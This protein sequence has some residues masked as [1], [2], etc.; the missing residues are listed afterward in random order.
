MSDKKS[1]FIN[2]SAGKEGH[3]KM[4]HASLKGKL[5]EKFH[6]VRIRVSVKSQV[7]LGSG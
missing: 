3:L 5:W 2:D 7:I 4:A 1:E 6:R